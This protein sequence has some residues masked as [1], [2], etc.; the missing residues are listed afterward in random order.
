MLLRPLTK[1]L[2]NVLWGIISHLCNVSQLAV[3]LC[4]NHFSA[5]SVRRN[6]AVLVEISIYEVG[7]S[8]GLCVNISFSWWISVVFH[9]RSN[10]VASI[11]WDASCRY[12]PIIENFCS[13]V[14]WNLEDLT[15]HISQPISNPL[16]Y[17]RRIHVTPVPWFVDMKTIRWQ[18]KRHSRHSHLTIL[19]AS[20]TNQNI[21]L[22]LSISNC[23][24]I[25][26]ETKKTQSVIKN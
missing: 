23:S 6:I 7:F 11:W 25:I 5:S 16:L 1:S 3:K 10:Y 4:R 8:R 20:L 14:V 15:G 21:L 24:F 2:K 12:C 18:I 13:H 26:P 9:D 22:F 19:C 17:M